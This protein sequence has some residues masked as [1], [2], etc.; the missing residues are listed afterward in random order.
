MRTLLSRFLVLALSLGLLT[1]SLLPASPALAQQSSAELSITIT[2]GYVAYLLETQLPPELL[3]GQAVPLENPRLGFA[4]GGVLLLTVNTEIAPFG[5]VEP[6]I[7]INVAVANNTLSVD[8]ETISLSGLVVPAAIL[9]AG[10]FDVTEIESLIQD[11]ANDALA[12]LAGDLG[13]QL[14]GIDTTNATLTIHLSS[15]P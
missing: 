3:E 13:I 2:D 8:I 4:P 12:G 6:T 11:Q 10:G 7:T 15:V 5:P 14:V 1:G 9:A